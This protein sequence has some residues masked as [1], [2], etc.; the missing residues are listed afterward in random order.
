MSRTVVGRIFWKELRT[1][2]SLWLGVTGL[3]LGIQALVTVLAI[4][5][6][7]QS[8]DFDLW[9]AGIL[10]SAYLGV[11][12]YAIASG[13]ASF[14]EECEGNTSVLL[15]TV[16][17]TRLEAFVGKWG[18]GLTSTGVLSV[19]LAIA[20]CLCCMIT[21]HGSH[22]DGAASAKDFVPG[23]LLSEH[24]FK[25]L[26][27]FVWIGC[28]IPIAFFAFC[29]LYSLLLSDGLLAAVSG[30]FSTILALVLGATLKELDLR[31]CAIWLSLTTGLLIMTDYLLTGIWL[32]QGNL[33]GSRWTGKLGGD[34]TGVWNRLSKRLLGT[35]EL[36]RI[37]EPVA[38][39]RRAL[40]R[41]A[42]KEFRQAWPYFKIMALVAT[43]A[44][45][46]SL[47]LPSIR[48]V[49]IT[50]PWL[51]GLV[52]PLVM[53]VGAYHADQ[54]NRAYRFFADRGLPTDGSWVLKHGIWLVHTFAI[55]AFALAIDRI[56]SE[57]WADLSYGFRGG[58]AYTILP[59]SSLFANVFHYSDRSNLTALG[60]FA[61][62]VMLGYSI[63]QRFSFAFPKGPM[64]FGMAMGTTVAACMTWSIFGFHAVPIRWT[65]GLIPPI[66]LAYTWSHTA[67]WQ[68]EQL[69]SYRWS[70][71][72]LWMLLP[73]AGIAVAVC[74][75][76][77]ILIR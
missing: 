61:L 1:Q 75:Y 42:W 5:H 7:H 48:L 73:F 37:G 76:W 2:R 13:A 9:Y 46:F 74:L 17:I 3:G 59:P 62:Y 45:V 68:T 24:E 23:R 27:T 33:L 40:Q 28:L 35:I 77:P 66:L 67:R 8:L 32:Q 25:N 30:T 38:P 11:V 43:V 49:G 6:R 12:L 69:Y 63:G 47:L 60:V 56:P 36:F 41:L 10:L 58:I 34:R 20:A 71:I 18:Y 70:L 31:G 51:V 57:F 50:A 53:G 14:T 72:A 54:K 29:A 16:P 4:H 52:S 22:T 44:I 55:C 65:I 19:V 15:R 64:A 39:W 26:L 21:W